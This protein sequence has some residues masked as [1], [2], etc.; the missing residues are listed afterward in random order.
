M[1]ETIALENPQYSGG[2][3]DDMRQGLS[4]T[5]SR[6]ANRSMIIWGEHCSECAAPACY[7]ACSFYSP[8]ADGHCRR[9]VHGI[10]DVD[11]IK[12][13]EGSATRIVFRQW[14]KLEGRGPV[15][16]YA[17]AAALE[18]QSNTVRGN[19]PLNFPYLARRA[20][21]K[22]TERDRSQSQGSPSGFDGFVI[23]GCA[24]TGNPVHFTLTIV[25]ANKATQAIFQ[26]KFVFHATW[27]RHVIPMA[28]IARQIDL[29]TDHLIQ[30]EPVGDAQGLEVIFGLIDFVTWAPGKAPAD[31]KAPLAAAKFAKVVVWD[32]DHPVWDGIL[33]EDGAEG[34]TLRHGVRTAMEALDARGILQSVASKNNLDEAEA[35]LA[36]HGLSE[37][38]LAPQIG[39]GPKSES[40]SRLAQILNLGLDSFVFIDDQAFE[41]GEVG[42]AH[43]FVTVLPETA[44]DGLLARSQFDVPITP[45]SKG[46]RALYAVEAQRSIAAETSGSDYQTFL[47]SCDLKLEIAPLT[48]AD[49]ERVYELSQ[50]T[51]QLNVAATRYSRDDVAAMISQSKTVQGWTMRC[52]D[53]F[54][55][56]GLIG[57][58]L[59]DEN[60]GQLL[61]FFMSCRVQR[62]QVEAAFLEWL[63]RKMMDAQCAKMSVRWRKA[64]RNGPAVEMFEVLGFHLYKDDEENGTLTR[65]LSDAFDGADIVELIIQAG[66]VCEPHNDQAEF[67]KAG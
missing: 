10:E 54:G 43:P 66:D 49:S 60:K 34:V 19:V 30:I 16:P 1:K 20:A 44:V 15:K 48:A 32:L 64:V 22:H 35:A 9:F 52:E 41:R 31:T 33:L 50:R 24:L 42:E 13:S 14:G 8:R 59:F 28:T 6:V 67:A 21:W 3:P 40:L 55:D 53:R 51:N 39:W 26:T 37:F 7:S 62:K 5:T 36:Y 17:A 56:Y 4:D 63:R 61:D 2:V 58:A 45:E 65:T 12:P 46:R 38:I 23:E 29:S 27:S 57:F 25:P 11:A 18:R 47:R